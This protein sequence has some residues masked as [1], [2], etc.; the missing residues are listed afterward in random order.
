MIGERKVIGGLKVKI[1]INFPECRG[2]SKKDG[3]YQRKRHE[4]E[5]SGLSI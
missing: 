5:F 4:D 2:R 3:T 1:N